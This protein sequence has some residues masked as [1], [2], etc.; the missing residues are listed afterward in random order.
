MLDELVIADIDRNPLSEHFKA[1]SFDAIIFGDVLE[2][3][4]DPWGGAA[5]RRHAAAARGSDPGLDPQRRSRRRPPGP[6]A[7][8]LGLHREGTAGPNPPALLHPGVGLRAARERRPGHRGA[9]LD[10]AGPDGG[11]GDQR[12]TPTAFPPTSSSGRASS[13]TRS[14]TSTSPPPGLCCRARTGAASGAGA[15]ARLRRGAP[16]RQ[17]HRP[18]RRPTWTSGT[19]C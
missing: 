13:R 16:A 3:L 14:T 9:A 12:W 11:P 10:R 18:V 19:A 1:E 8:P 2:H 7:G 5:R 4:I 6:A 17:V 15:G